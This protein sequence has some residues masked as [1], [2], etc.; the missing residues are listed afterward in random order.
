MTH[1]FIL[2]TLPPCSLLSHNFTLPA[3]TM[4]SK[5]LST[6]AASG[7]APKKSGKTDSED[8]QAAKAEYMYCK[9]QVPLILYS[10]KYACLD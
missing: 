9:V 2:A 6:S 10:L 1:Y 7:S 8:N 3:T 4:D 5:H